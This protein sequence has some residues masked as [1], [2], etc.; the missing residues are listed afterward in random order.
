MNPIAIP[1]TE[2]KPALVGLGKVINK[3]SPSPVL[4]CVHIERTR[5]G[6]IELSATDLDVSVAVQ[7]DSPT[8]GEPVAF[9]VPY[10]D[11]SNTAKSCGKHGTLFIAPPE[12]NRVAIKFPVGGQMIEHRCESLP[13]EEFSAIAPVHSEPVAIDAALQGAIQD[14]FGCASVDQ[15][16]HM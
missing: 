6:S 16:R 12:K 8:Q 10:E 3:R 5:T 13:V 9:L 4:G 15:T 14:A 1:M 7:L 2:L 11:L